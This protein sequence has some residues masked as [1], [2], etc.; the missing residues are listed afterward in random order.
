M[1]NKKTLVAISLSILLI[2]VIP[3]IAGQEENERPEREEKPGFDSN[4]DDSI[5]YREFYAGLAGKLDDATIKRVFEAAD[6]D[7][8]GKLSE[9]ELY[10]AIE[11]LQKLRPVDDE[12]D[13]EERKAQKERMKRA[14]MKKIREKQAEKKAERKNPDLDGDGAISLREFYNMFDGK[15]DESAIKRIFNAADG[16]GDGELNKREMYRAWEMIKSLKDDDDKE[17]KDCDDCC[18]KVKEVKKD[19]KI[20]GEKVKKIFRTLMG[21]DADGD[22]EIT[23]R[24]VIQILFKIG[25]LLTE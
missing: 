25:R 21:I 18:D 5:S 20:D 10:R 17:E 22:G 16:D 11:L 4:D 12:D 24:E 13:K 14:R 1:L 6:V 3:M 7:E 8:D 9:R 2:G 23:L 15:L 19:F